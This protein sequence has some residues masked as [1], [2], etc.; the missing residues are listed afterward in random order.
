[1]YYKLKYSSLLTI[2][3]KNSIIYINGPLGSNSINIPNSIK[4]VLN[5]CNNYILFHFGKLSIKK[6]KRNW[7]G[8]LSQFHSVCRNLV[9]GDLVALNIK[10][11][12]LRFLNINKLSNNEKYLSMR[13]GYSNSINRIIN[14]NCFIYFFKDNRNIIIYSVD[15]GFLRN[16]ISNLISLKPYNKFIKRENGI[17]I[18]RYIF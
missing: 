17:S 6:N 9:F 7:L 13:L 1:M 5:S 14:S 11:L 16:E 18:I 3:K 15:F 2:K 12:G 4:I 8:F 10:G